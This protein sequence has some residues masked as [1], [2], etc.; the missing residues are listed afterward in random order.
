MS[1]QL[2]FTRT[3]RYLVVRLAI[4]LA[5]N[6]TFCCALNTEYNLQYIDNFHRYGKVGQAGLPT[7]SDEE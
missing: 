7:P 3:S 4:T 5:L 1:G 2:R 6:R